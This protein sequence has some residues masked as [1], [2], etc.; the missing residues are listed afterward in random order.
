MSNDRAPKKMPPAPRKTSPPLRTVLV[1]VTYQMEVPLVTVGPRDT[2]IDA[3][4]QRDAEAMVTESIS[5]MDW[6][7]YSML[8]KAFTRRALNPWGAVR[9]RVVH[10]PLT[11]M[12]ERLLSRGK[13][14]VRALA[15]WPDEQVV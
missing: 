15:T 6:G 8:G 5:A 14:A 1:E 3:R 2:P 11:T 12:S 9:V 7:G 13:E 4:L 10:K